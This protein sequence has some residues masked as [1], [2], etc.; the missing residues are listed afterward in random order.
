MFVHLPAKSEYN[1]SEG[2]NG[3]DIEKM[4]AELERSGKAEELR[5]LA[6]SADGRALNAMFDAAAVA[7]AVSS[8]DREAMQG[9]LRQV[10]NTDEG[11]RIAKQLSDA[12]NK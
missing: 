3:M 4:S 7:R 1:V 10:L 12:M 9:I 2:V 11:R 6:E 8:G 5:K